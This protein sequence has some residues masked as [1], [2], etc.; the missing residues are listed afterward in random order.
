V[1]N[2][3]ADQ[4]E[5]FVGHLLALDPSTTTWLFNNTEPAKDAIACFEFSEFIAGMSNLPSNQWGLHPAVHVK[6]P[7]LGS[8]SDGPMLYSRG[9]TRDCD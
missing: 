3:L 5:V 6:K 7:P 1:Q 9:P 4:F 8:N 2:D